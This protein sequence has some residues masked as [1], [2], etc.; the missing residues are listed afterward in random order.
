MGNKVKLITPF[1]MLLAGAIA[2]V[3]MY[4]RKFEFERM[5]WVLLLVLIVFYFIGDVIRYI[6]AAIRPRIITQDVDYS[7]YIP[8][9][10]FA[11]ES[12]N[13]RAYA[14]DDEDEDEEFDADAF[15]ASADTSSSVSDS[16]EEGYSEEEL[17]EYT[18]DAE[19]SDDENSDE[20]EAEY[21]E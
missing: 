20:D 21:D 18:D 13:V 11:E 12:G 15:L 2:A 14:D 17:Q 8:L 1:I 6:Y 16:T 9:S 5:L 19:D 7:D 10:R 3:I 4:I